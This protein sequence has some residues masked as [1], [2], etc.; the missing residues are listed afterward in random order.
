MLVQKPMFYLACLA[1]IQR[2]D[3][4][5]ESSDLLKLGNLFCLSA[6]GLKVE[7]I[8]SHHDFE[9]I[10][11]FLHLLELTR[12][13]QR[14]YN[15]GCI[16]DWRALHAFCIIDTI[17]LIKSVEVK[18]TAGCN[19]CSIISGDVSNCSYGLKAHLVTSSRLSL[20]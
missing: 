1:L 14:T 16:Y 10:I 18:Q 5:F 6:C 9:Y 2:Q 3:S 12:L 19:S 8:H 13:R 20:A 11:H 15:N 7:G 17:I 4:T